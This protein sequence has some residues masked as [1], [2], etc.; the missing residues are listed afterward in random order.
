MQELKAAGQPPFRIDSALLAKL[1]PGLVLTQ[2]SCS[3]CDPVADAAA[4]V[5]ALF[6]SVGARCHCLGSLAAVQ[7]RVSTLTAGSVLLFSAVCGTGTG[8]SALKHVCQWTMHRGCTWDCS[9][10]V[11]TEMTGDMQ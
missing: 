10:S 7:G 3:V 9:K 6:G 4:E 5:S 1:Q 11:F 8:M 2:S